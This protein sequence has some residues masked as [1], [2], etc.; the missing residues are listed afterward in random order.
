ME[1]SLFQEKVKIIYE[2]I[3]QAF[4]SKSASYF[5]D[6]R[7]TNLRRIVNNIDNVDETYKT[8]VDIKR[9]RFDCFLILHFNEK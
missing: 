5:I 4:Q 6:E 3:M 2:R 1:L 9:K 8:T 7:I